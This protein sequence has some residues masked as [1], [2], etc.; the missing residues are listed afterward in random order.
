MHAKRLKND[1]LGCNICQ[2]L[3][4][5]LLLIILSLDTSQ[6]DRSCWIVRLWTR[7][8]SKQNKSNA[9]IITD[10]HVKPHSIFIKMCNQHITCF[11]K[12]EK[13]CRE[14]VNPTVPQEHQPTRI[15]IH[16]VGQSLIG[17]LSQSPAVEVV[18]VTDQ[19][20][21]RESRQHS[22][23]KMLIQHICMSCCI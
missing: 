15:Q 4:R 23:C 22:Y 10:I 17:F 19:A 12:Q 7:Q 20:T 3:T 18:H 9:N 6:C 8:K 1:S 13:T 2:N 5:G 21:Q 14:Q 16:T 11:E